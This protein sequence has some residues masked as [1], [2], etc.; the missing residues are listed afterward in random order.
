MYTYRL[1]FLEDAD[2]S[3]PTHFESP[4]PVQAGDVIRVSNG[5]HHLVHEVAEADS[6]EPLLRL[7]KSGQGPLDATLQT[8][9]GR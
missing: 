7:G 5:Y 6:P 3:C 8:L 1:D 9:I 4:S 2:D